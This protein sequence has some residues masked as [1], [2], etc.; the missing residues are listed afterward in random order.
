MSKVISR[1]TEVKTSMKKTGLFGFCMAS[2]LLKVLFS[3]IRESRAIGFS[4]VF[5]FHESSLNFFAPIASVT[6]HSSN[7]R[8]RGSQ[9]VSA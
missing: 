1:I 9:A 2:K 8:G 6:G 3:K 4:I 5:S 7:A